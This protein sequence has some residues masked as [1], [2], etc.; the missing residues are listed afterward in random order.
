V[1][2]C[3]RARHGAHVL[4]VVVGGDRRNPGVVAESGWRTVAT[5]VL[6]YLLVMSP[7]LKLSYFDFHGGR[8]EP[9]RVALSIAGIAF[10]DDRVAFNDWTARKPTTPFGGMPI[11]E[12]DGKR[13][14]QS[15]AINRYVGRL[16]GLYPDDPWQAALCDQV[17][18]AIESLYGEMLASFRIKDPDQFK[19]ER[20]RLVD[21]PVPMYL[22][23][24]Q[25]LLVEAGG[26]WFAD[27]RLTMADL[28][29]V[30]VVRH[31]ASGRLDHV[32]TDIVPQI[33]PKLAEHRDRV[34]AHPGVSAYYQ[35]VG[36]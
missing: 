30:D 32:P 36:A 19:Q 20:A 9:A 27:G 29:M 17:S 23:G 33:A 10:Q 3:A 21:G 4:T 2:V 11:L 7:T 16:A 26:Q 8:G 14:T 1:R 22:K 18:D 28:K 12:V 5:T 13:L 25:G 6:V 35:R 24:L 15:N 31:F 34:L